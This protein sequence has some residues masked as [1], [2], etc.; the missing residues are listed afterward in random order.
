VVSGV[1]VGTVV[2][3]MFVAMP[4]T[5]AIVLAANAVWSAFWKSVAVPRALFMLLIAFVIVVGILAVVVKAWVE[6]S[7]RRCS[8]S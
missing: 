7:L 4:C 6:D 8:S 1:A 2:E 3:V 5:A